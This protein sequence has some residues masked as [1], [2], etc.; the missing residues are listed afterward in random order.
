MAYTLQS[1]FPIS[2][3]L[4]TFWRDPGF[5][6]Q[7]IIYYIFPDIFW[8]NPLRFRFT[9][10]PLS[11]LSNAF[12]L[13]PIVSHIQANVCSSFKSNADFKKQHTHVHNATM[14]QLTQDS[15]HEHNN[16]LI[17]IFATVIIKGPHLTL[18]SGE[19]C[20]LS[21]STVNCTIF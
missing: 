17:I 14:I 3:C 6:Q 18:F 15:N 20:L 10:S 7:S 19:R 11:I 1:S 2:I 9:S 21:V 5:L 4:L 12:R 16:K 8:R 13:I